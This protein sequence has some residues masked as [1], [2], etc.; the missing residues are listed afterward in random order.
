MHI[1]YTHINVTLWTKPVSTAPG[2]NFDYITYNNDINLKEGSKQAIVFLI[3]FRI[4]IINQAYFKS[5]IPLVEEV[6]I[7]FA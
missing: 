7:L 4:I 3:N 2:L 1:L 6:K 5:L